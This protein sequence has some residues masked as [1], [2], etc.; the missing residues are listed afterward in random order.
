M[1]LTAPSTKG[2]AYNSGFDDESGSYLKVLNDHLQYRYE[3]LEIIGKVSEWSNSCRGWLLYR[4][5]LGQ[6]SKLSITRVATWLRLK[7][8]ATKHAS[9]S[10]AWLKS[11]YSTNCAR[12][13]RTKSW[14]SFTWSITST[15]GITCAL[16][17]SSSG[18]RFY[19]GATAKPTIYFSMNLYELI[20]KHN[21]QGFSLSVV[22][23][24]AIAI[25]RCLRALYDEKIIHC[26]LKPVRAY[27]SRQ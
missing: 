10:K 4:V 17:S 1:I 23:R 19:N 25:L 24:I 21:F 5:H 7:L 20:K 6:L 13:T 9:T 27:F 2:H 11:K 8:Y 12:R 14:T 3:V 22:R 26:D 15:S 18:K 16:A